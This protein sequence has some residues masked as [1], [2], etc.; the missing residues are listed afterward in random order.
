MNMFKSTGASTIKE[1]MDQVPDDRK[2]LIDTLD[3]LIKQS[4][5]KLKPYFANNMLGYGSF[6]YLDYKKDEIDWPVIA[7][8]NQKNYVSIYVCALKDGQYIAEMYKDK[9]GKVSIGKSCI[10][11][12]KLEKVNMDTLKTVIIEATKYPGLT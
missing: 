12:N 1:Y 11:F 10:R 2:E 4:A 7:L 3:K 8:A 9:L 6:K 5:P